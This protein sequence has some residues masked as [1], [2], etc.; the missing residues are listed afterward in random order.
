MLQDTPYRFEEPG[1]FSCELDRGEATNPLFLVNHWISDDPPDPNVAAAVNA[2][3]VLLTRAQESAS[4][5]VHVPNILAVDFET[6]GDLFD[7]VDVL[8]GFPRP[9]W[10]NRQHWDEM[11]PPF[12]TRFGVVGDR[13]VERSDQA[14]ALL[15]WV[16]SGDRWTRRL[17]ASNSR[18][19]SAS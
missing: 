13:I 12:T 5:R 1:E 8:N 11:S 15:T 2:R 3:D 17:N 18:A 19:G 14:A 4:E 6:R 16:H 7:V 9:D 10:S